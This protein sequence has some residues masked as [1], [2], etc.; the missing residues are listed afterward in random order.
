MSCSKAQIESLDD[1]R[2]NNRLLIIYSDD[3]SMQEDQ[4][5]NIT[6][7][8]KEYDERD[9]K[10]IIL[11]DQKV[12]VWN[13]STVHQL[14]FDQIVQDLKISVG[15]SYQNLLI[16]KDGGVKLRQDSPIS[17]QTLFNTIDAMPMRQRE[18][19]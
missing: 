4:L 14:E 12:T 6:Q 8:R 16:G 9:L 2:W 7:A 5:A 10:V 13:S 3:Q 19:H 11:K 15:I 17:N 1:F 18:M